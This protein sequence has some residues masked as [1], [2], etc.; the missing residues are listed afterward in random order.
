[1][2]SANM[3][4][5]LRPCSLWKGGFYIL[6]KDYIFKLVKRSSTDPCTFDQKYKC[7]QPKLYSDETASLNFIHTL[8]ND[9]GYVTAP[10][11]MS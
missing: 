1:M 10:L 7:K 6:L 11:C 5:G 2:L 3:F 9:V 4:Y 8:P